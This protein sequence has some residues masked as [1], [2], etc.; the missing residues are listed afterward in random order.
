MSGWRRKRPKNDFSVRLYGKYY[1]ALKPK[2]PLVTTCC[3]SLRWVNAYPLEK[4]TAAHDFCMDCQKLTTVEFINLEQYN[5]YYTNYP[6]TQE[7]FDSLWR[8]I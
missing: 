1:R 5:K 7:H 2:R 3:G 8:D 6:I 4:N